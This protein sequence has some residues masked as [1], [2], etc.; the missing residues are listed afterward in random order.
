MINDRHIKPSCGASS[1]QFPYPTGTN[2]PKFFA[3][4]IGTNKM[5]GGPTIK[6][7]SPHKIITLNH[8]RSKAEHKGKSVFGN[9]G[10]IVARCVCYDN[11]PL[12]CLGSVVVIVSHSKVGVDFDSCS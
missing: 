12:F 9:T 3:L 10:C 11:P 7:S 1:D 6:F 4:K 8:P 2:K 5:S